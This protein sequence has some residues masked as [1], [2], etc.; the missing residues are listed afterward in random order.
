[1]A[2]TVELLLTDNVEN[3]GI[4][5]DIVNVK[6][7]YAR[8]FLLPR[9]LGAKPTEDLKQALAEKRAVAER[10]MRELRSQRETM[11][12]KLAEHEVTL[13][14][15]CNDQGLLYGSVTQ[16]DI[17]DALVADG[18]NVRARDVRLGQTIKRIDSYQVLVKLDAD[19]EADMKV[20]VVADRQ[21]D[22]DEREEMEFDNEGNLIEKESKPATQQDEQSGDDAAE[23]SA[24]PAQA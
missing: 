6:L 2:K 15:S 24:E 23:A 12:D 1:M 5:G 13:E 7:G 14:R 17:A 16:R 21:I 8:N 20:W 3:L 19:L 10:Q 18:F 9:G 11:I 4:V 22:M